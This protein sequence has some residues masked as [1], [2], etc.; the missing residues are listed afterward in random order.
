ML[1][2]AGVMSPG[3]KQEIETLAGRMAAKLPTA[4]RDL[5]RKMADELIALTE[6]VGDGLVSVASAHLPGVPLKTVPGTH[7]SM[8]RSLTAQS[9]RIP[10]A[11]PMIVEALHQ[12][13]RGE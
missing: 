3:Q 4:A 6:Q 10:P 12:A 1:V 13:E 11:I 5:T 9:R 7:L 8:I 2:I